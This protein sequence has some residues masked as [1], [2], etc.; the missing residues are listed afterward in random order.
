[1]TVLSLLLFF[2]GAVLLILG[3]RW[4]YPTSNE[5]LTAMKGMVHLKSEINRLEKE[6]NSFN[7]KLV[8]KQFSPLAQ[9]QI[10]SAYSKHNIILDDVNS[11]DIGDTLDNSDTSSNEDALPEKYQQV[12]ELVNYDFTVSEISEKLRMSQDAVIMVMRTAKCRNRLI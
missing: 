1:M 8:D 9:D 7:E 5:F 3:W 6:L 2:I 11:K 12:L 4:Q 10:L